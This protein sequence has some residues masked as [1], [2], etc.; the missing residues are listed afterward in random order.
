MRK[1]SYS[2]PTHSAADGA[3]AEGGMLAGQLLPT[4]AVDTW[5]DAETSAESSCF[6]GF[7]DKL[8]IPSL[9]P[10]EKQRRARRLAQTLEAKRSQ[11][12]T[13]RGIS[14]LP[15]AGRC[16]SRTYLQELEEEVE[17][18]ASRWKKLGETRHPVDRPARKPP[19]VQ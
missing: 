19:A 18:L 12:E 6:H 8:Q 15:F 1:S 17:W 4:I 16:I 5:P 2:S 14:R 3:V 7:A 10:A 11:L 13:M 9:N